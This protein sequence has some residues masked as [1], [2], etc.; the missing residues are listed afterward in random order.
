LQLPIENDHERYLSFIEEGKDQLASWLG[1]TIVHSVDDLKK[2]GATEIS[3]GLPEFSEHEDT[4]YNG[5][6][7]LE[8]KMVI[9]WKVRTNE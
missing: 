2:E 7:I 9:S 3:L 6:K 8:M 4:L 1:K 5:G